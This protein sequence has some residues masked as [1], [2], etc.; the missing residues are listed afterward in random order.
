MAKAKGKLHAAHQSSDGVVWALLKNTGKGNGLGK[1]QN[2]WV[3]M[4]NQEKQWD[5]GS[6]RHWGS[7]GARA[8]VTPTR[9]R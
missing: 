8:E 6:S 9:C 2:S 4:R 1:R 7:L 5:G 3:F